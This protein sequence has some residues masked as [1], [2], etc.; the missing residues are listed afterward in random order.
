MNTFVVD[1]IIKNALIEDIGTGDITTLSTVPADTIATARII[2][3]ESGVLCGIIIAKRVFALTDDT[4]SFNI[5][6]QDGQTVQKGDILALI[7]GNARSMLTGERV[8]LNFLQR[9][10]GIATATANA[11]DKVRGTKAKICDTRKTVPG[12]RVLEK[13]A[14]KTGGGFN[15]RFNLSDGVLIKDNHIKAAGGITKAIESVKKMAPHTLRIEVEV[16]NEAM[17]R[18]ALECGED[19]IMLDNMTTKQMTE[20]VKLIGSKSL[21]EASGNM[22][23]K[24]LAEVAATG[25]DLIS[26]GSLTHS[27]KALDI[28][29]KFD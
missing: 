16:A 11:M 15:H 22:G 17:V 14:V 29:L 28:S 4:V 24:N 2:A 18:E 19:I 7:S 8:A 13:Y 26:L 25:V 5:Q 10:S 21:V 1:N 20:A 6:K 9:M 23:D 27:V 12:L 3:K